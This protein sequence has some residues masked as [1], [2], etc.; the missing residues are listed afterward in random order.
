MDDEIEGD[1]SS[2]TTS[3]MSDRKAKVQIVGRVSGRRIWTVEQKL[4][5]IGE[6]FSPGTSVKQTV[7]RHEIGSGQLYTWR[8]QLLDGELGGPRDIGRLRSAPSFARVV[9]ASMPDG[10][11]ERSPAPDTSPP[12]AI[13]SHSFAR[14][15]AVANARAT[16]LAGVIEI[17][18]PSGARVRVDGGVD[19]QALK[20]VLE[21]LGSLGRAGLAWR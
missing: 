19:G 1:A 11:A 17:E 16:A 9:L 7:E 6:A 12:L 18:L 2:H 3:R 15:G 4:A 13:D 10:A 5:I 21:A 14:E 8:R 20:R